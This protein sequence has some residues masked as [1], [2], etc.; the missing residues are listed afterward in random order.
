MALDEGEVIEMT[1]DAGEHEPRRDDE[2]L[3]LVL[4]A[5]LMEETWPR[6]G[7]GAECRAARTST[8]W[9]DVLS[10]SCRTLSVP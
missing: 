10:T 8:A 5:V 3:P 1:V 9:S 6:L 4:R 2:G 7:G